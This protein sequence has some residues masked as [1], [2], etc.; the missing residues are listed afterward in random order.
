MAWPRKPTVLPLTTTKET[1]V[2]V[3][4]SVIAVA[5]VDFI[6]VVAPAVVVIMVIPA[7]P[8]LPPCRLHY[9]SLDSASVRML[10]KWI[11]NGTKRH[12]TSAD[13]VEDTVHKCLSTRWA[14]L[15]PASGRTSTPKLFT[16]EKTHITAFRRTYECLTR[17]PPGREG[18]WRPCMISALSVQPELPVAQVSE[19]CLLQRLEDPGKHSTAQPSADC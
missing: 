15:L 14:R 1:L 4:F 6:I 8:P 7:V 5:A 17:N 11:R 9:R 12:F 18:L 3:A 10:M 19:H 13:Q 2:C 16:M